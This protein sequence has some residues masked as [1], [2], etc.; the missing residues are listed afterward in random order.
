[1]GE[2]QGGPPRWSPFGVDR[3]QISLRRINATVVA[4]VVVILFI[5]RT[6]VFATVR[7][8]GIGARLGVA[9]VA[10]LAIDKTAP[11][12][13]A[14]PAGQHICNIIRA[15]NTSASRK[16]LHSCCVCPPP[17]PIPSP[18][19]TPDPAPRPAQ[20]LPW[21]ENSVP[22]VTHTAL[23]TFTTGIALYCFV[24]CVVIDPGRCVACGSF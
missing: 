4:V 24:A 17:T 5:Y 7:E 15:S 9:S 13:S 21:L 14:S 10:W 12:D 23:L 8:H 22:G 20:V 6:V 2:E 11:T 3:S 16:R 19:P 18:A 1:M